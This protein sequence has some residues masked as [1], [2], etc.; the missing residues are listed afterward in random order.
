MW[1]LLGLQ[2]IVPGLELLETYRETA[3]NLKYGGTGKA[4]KNEPLFPSF[5]NQFPLLHLGF[6]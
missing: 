3:A 6:Q 2:L 4:K 1:H 5:L